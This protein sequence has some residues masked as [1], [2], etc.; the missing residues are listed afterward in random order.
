MVLFGRLGETFPAPVAELAYAQRLGRCPARVRGSNPLGGT[1]NLAQGRSGAIPKELIS[2]SKKNSEKYRIYL[3]NSR[4]H[5]LGTC[6]HSRPK[7][8]NEGRSLGF[9]VCRLL[10]CSRYYSPHTSLR[11]T[12]DTSTSKL[13]NVASWLHF[14]LG[15]SC[16]TCKLFYFSC[17]QDTR[18]V[19]CLCF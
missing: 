8:F 7:N 19:R 12:I 6:I 17:N 10:A 13:R 16:S 9:I 4:R 15:G 18:G 1:K 11:S 14:H 2:V 3:C 5:Y